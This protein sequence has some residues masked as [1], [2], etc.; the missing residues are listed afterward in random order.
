MAVSLLSKLTWDITSVS[1]ERNYLSQ[2]N[3][4]QLNSSRGKTVFTSTRHTQLKTISPRVIP[5][6]RKTSARRHQRASRPEESA[7][8]KFPEAGGRAITIKRIGFEAQGK[9]WENFPLNL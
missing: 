2:K 4:A 3:L 6:G 9:D 7:R 1:P 8:P 5:T